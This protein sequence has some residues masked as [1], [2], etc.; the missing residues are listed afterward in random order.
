M[1]QYLSKKFGKFAYCPFHK[2]EQYTHTGSCVTISNY[3][4]TSHQIFFNY[5]QEKLEFPANKHTYILLN[6]TVTVGY[7]PTYNMD[8]QILEIKAVS[9]N[10]TFSVA[11]AILKLTFFD[12]WTTRKVYPLREAN[13]KY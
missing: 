7:L 4:L 2:L 13:Y 1:F 10:H 11:I 3:V 6:S 8:K 9:K 12:L 5:M